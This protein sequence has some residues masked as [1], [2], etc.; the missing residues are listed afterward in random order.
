MTINTRNYGD[1]DNV[2]SDVK[3]LHD[4]IARQGSH[5]VT[6]C[7]AESL[8]TTS[9]KFGLSF[10]CSKRVLNAMVKDLTEQTL[11]RI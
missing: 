1:A 11:E 8:G 5:L 10:N 7:L 4:I 3:A 2:A 6:A 9:L